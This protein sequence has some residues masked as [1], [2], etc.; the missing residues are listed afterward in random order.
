MLHL[1]PKLGQKWNKQFC[2]NLGDKLLNTLRGMR[3]LISRLTAQVSIFI[4]LVSR[5]TNL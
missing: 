2:P 4:K 3:L 1:R 5:Q